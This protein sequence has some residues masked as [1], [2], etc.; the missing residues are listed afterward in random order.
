MKVNWVS[1]ILVS[2]LVEYSGQ[3][4]A[5]KNNTSSGSVAAGEFCFPKSKSP[6]GS[7][8]IDSSMRGFSTTVCLQ[9][10]KWKPRFN[11]IKIK[12]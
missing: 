6:T 1:N 4:G 9:F 2:V 10:I 8:Q 12:I 5:I 7:S 11:K 3:V